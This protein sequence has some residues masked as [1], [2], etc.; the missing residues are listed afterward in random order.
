M[1]QMNADGEGAKL[2]RGKA[3]SP[4]GRSLPRTPRKDVPSQAVHFGRRLGPG[5]SYGSSRS[6][7]TCRAL[8]DA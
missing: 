2:T 5:A 3:C 7:A 4:M 1:A 8:H 6:I